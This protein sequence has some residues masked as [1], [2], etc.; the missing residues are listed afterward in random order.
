[1]EKEKI[2]EQVYVSPQDIKKL[3]PTLGMDLCRKFIDEARA[4]MTEKGYFV[5]ETKPKIAL[6]KIVK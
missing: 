3:V 1:M 5:P 6:T 4:E 2:L